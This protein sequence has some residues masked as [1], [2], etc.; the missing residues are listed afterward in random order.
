MVCVL[1]F[2]Q[3]CSKISDRGVM[4][5]IVGNPPLTA[6]HGTQFTAVH[7]SVR[8]KGMYMYSVRLE[9]LSS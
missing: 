9:S 5:V 8:T 4:T 3:A 2:G 6:Q 1:G 7:N